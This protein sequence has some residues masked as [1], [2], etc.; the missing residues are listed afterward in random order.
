M[1][2]Q[3][4]HHKD[5]SQ[6][7]FLITGGAG[8]IGSHI[9]EYLLRHGAK[10]VRV[11]DDL[12]T[13]S[14]SNVSL[15]Q[16]HPNYEFL[17]EDIRDL[18]SCRRACKGIDII[19]HQAA[20]GSVPRSLKDPYTTLSVNVSGFANVVKAASEEGIQRMVYASSSSVY[21][22]EPNLP[23]QED[24]IGRQLSPYAVSKYANELLA[25]VFAEQYGIELLGFRYF[26]VFGSRQRPDGPYAAVIPLFIERLLNQQEV[27]IDGDGLQTR[28]FTYIENVV[29][30]NVLG[31]LNAQSSDCNGQI[32]NVA[33]GE[34]YSVL[35]L[36]QMI[37][38]DLDVSQPPQHRAAR[39]GDV[40][41][42]HADVSKATQLLGYAPQVSFQKGLKR[43]IAF[44]EE[45]YLASRKEG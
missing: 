43:T 42:S 32:I 28:D 31:M 11:I 19:A 20:I 23:K 36:Y 18:D 9:V 33:F 45:V 41:D 17:Q 1:Y 30:A 21:G 5:I 3:A 38:K 6:L 37:A 4:F 24:R 40:R 13:G 10:K 35:D 44:F 14:A 15:F 26:N 8:F 25:S 16:E 39:K 22:D 2:E 29:Q 27:F 7:S 34:R 12:S